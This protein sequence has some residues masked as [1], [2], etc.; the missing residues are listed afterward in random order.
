MISINC[1]VLLIYTE[2]A[3][4][5]THDEILHDWEWLHANLMDTLTSFDTEEEITE[6]VCCKVQSIIANSAP[7]CQFADGKTLIIII[8]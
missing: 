6:F 2:V 5:L 7:D 1:I 8:N 3:C 4:S